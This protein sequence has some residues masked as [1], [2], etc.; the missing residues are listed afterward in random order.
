MTDTVPPSYPPHPSG[1]R[2]IDH[3][4]VTA[5]LP[6]FVSQVVEKKLSED[7]ESLV[8]MIVR[9]RLNELQEGCQCNNSFKQY[10]YLGIFRC[11]F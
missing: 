6:L 9:K 10:V 4:D 11:L 7:L 5:Y 1:A 2:P 3:V 8:N